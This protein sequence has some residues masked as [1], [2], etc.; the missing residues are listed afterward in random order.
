MHG[1]LA[2]GYDRNPMLS[3]WRKAAGVGLLLLML[4]GLAAPLAA[5]FASQSCC[6]SMATATGGQDEGPARCQWM[7]PTSC[8]DESVLAVAAPVFVPAPPAARV[9]AAVPPIPQQHLHTPAAPTPPTSQA[10]AL[11]TIVLRL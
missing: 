7:A 3:Q 9:Q 2:G 6:G 10:V 5:A 4:A 1:D 8:C 11:S